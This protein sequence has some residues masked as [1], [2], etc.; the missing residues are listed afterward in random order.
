MSIFIKRSGINGES[1]DANHREWID[2]L[3]LQWNVSRK[4]TSN[5]STRG[6]RESANATIGDLI[7]V[8]RLDKATPKL[9]IESCCGKGDDFEIHLTKTGHGNGTGVYICAIYFAMPS[10]AA[11]V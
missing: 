8:R 11:I 4:I 2:A 5:T 3:T 9:F 6:D 7:I 1:A 10:L